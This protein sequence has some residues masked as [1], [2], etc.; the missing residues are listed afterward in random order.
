MQLIVLCLCVCAC[1]V[2][3]D[4]EAMR[5]MPKYDSRYDYLDVDGLFNSKRLVKN[6]VECLVNGQRCSPEGKALKSE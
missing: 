6:Y 5:N 4:I 1:V 2:G 3:Q